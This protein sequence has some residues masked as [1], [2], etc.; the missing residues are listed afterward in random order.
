[1]KDEADPIGLGANLI[2]LNLGE[3]KEC[4]LLYTLK[5]FLGKIDAIAFKF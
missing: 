1:M 4:P 3:D 5:L 2:L